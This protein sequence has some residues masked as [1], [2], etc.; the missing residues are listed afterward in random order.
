VTRVN[1]VNGVPYINDPVILSWQ[2]AN[3]PRPGNMHTTKQQK[4][5]YRKWIEDTARYIHQIDPHHMVSTGSE[6]VIGS[7]GDERLYARAHA[8]SQI[9]YLTCHLWAKTWGWF[10]PKNAVKTWDKGLK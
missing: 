3:E 8:S 4:Q 6:G 7:G 10:D 5:I 1:S 2:L 9:D